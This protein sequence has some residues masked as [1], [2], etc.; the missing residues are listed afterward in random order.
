LPLLHLPIAEPQHFEPVETE[1]GVALAIVER[2]LPPPMSCPPVD[3]DHEPLLPP[4]EVGCEPADLHVHFGQ[5]EPAAA[6]EAQEVALE[7]A[8]GSVERSAGERKPAVLGGASRAADL[9]RR[10][11]PP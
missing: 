7:V 6:A 5:R 11:H 2:R 4:E 9:G 10:R 8:A 3:L 1:I